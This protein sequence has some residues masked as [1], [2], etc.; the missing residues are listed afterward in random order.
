MRRIRWQDHYWGHQGFRKF[1]ELRS[2][3][4]VETMGKAQGTEGG[5]QPCAGKLLVALGD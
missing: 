4:C 5:S 1:L 2:D 3:G